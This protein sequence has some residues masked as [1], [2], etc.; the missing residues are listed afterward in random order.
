MNKQVTSNL[1][2]APV[3]QPF[4]YKEKLSVFIR[5][6]WTLGAFLYSLIGIKLFCLIYPIRVIVFSESDT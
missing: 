2:I 4:Y 3:R 5:I 6:Y 1:H